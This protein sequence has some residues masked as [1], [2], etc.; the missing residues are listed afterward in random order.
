MGRPG[1]QVIVMPLLMF[2]ALGKCVHFTSED[3][4]QLKL[5]KNFKTTCK[6]FKTTCTLCVCYWLRS[7]V[8]CPLLQ[9][10]SVFINFFQLPD[11]AF[12]NNDDVN[13]QWPVC[14]HL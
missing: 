7:V 14:C 10:S 4:I 9:S 8:T 2:G 13:E 3:W 6:N 11:W 1:I 12:G 5:Y